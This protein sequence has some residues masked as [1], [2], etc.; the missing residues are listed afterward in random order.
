MIAS[1]PAVLELSLKE[2]LKTHLVERRSMNP[3]PSIPRLLCPP[4]QS[5][6]LL[7]IVKV[8]PGRHQVGPCRFEAIRHGPH[9]G[10]FVSRDIGQSRPCR[11]GKRCEGEKREMKA[12]ST[13]VKAE[14]GQG[15]GRREQS[16]VSER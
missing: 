2:R 4:R 8:G 9:P 6:T 7:R 13:L 15:G 1:Q 11:I 16:E 3:L 14:V 5:N 12:L 10:S